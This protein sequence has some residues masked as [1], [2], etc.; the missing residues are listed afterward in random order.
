[1]SCIN[2]QHHPLPHPR[3]EYC[4]TDPNVARRQLVQT[5]LSYQASAMWHD[6]YSDSP[7]ASAEL[8]MKEDDL[9]TAAAEHLRAQTTEQHLD[10]AAHSWAAAYVDRI[11][12]WNGQGPEPAARGAAYTAACEA[13][14]V[15]H[16]A[17]HRA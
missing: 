8:E 17:A 11:H 7:H 9:T 13:Y 16:R 2:R 4:I 12:P 10:D 15:A 1:V 6:E 3:N 5:A 14:A